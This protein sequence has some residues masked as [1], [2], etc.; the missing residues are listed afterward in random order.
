MTGTI[1]AAVVPDAR[2]RLCFSFRRI[3]ATKAEEPQNVKKALETP[4]YQ[5]P[6]FGEKEKNEGNL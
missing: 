3:Y 1:Y 4:R 6:R 5:R 2:I